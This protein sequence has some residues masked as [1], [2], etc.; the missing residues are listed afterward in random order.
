MLLWMYRSSLSM[1]GVVSGAQRV[2]YELLADTQLISGWSGPDQRCFW[3]Y[4]ACSLGLVLSLPH[5]FLT[6]GSRR[7]HVCSCSDVHQ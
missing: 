2:S 3:K 1:V 6:V 5:G 7:A 4:R